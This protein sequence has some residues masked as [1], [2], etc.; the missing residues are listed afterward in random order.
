MVQFAP[1]LLSFYDFMVEIY[2]R[3]TKLSSNWVLLTFN[4]LYPWKKIIKSLSFRAAY[5]IY[6]NRAIRKFD[7]QKNPI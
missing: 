6:V 1:K 2:N 3:K 7:V 4:Y 5:Q